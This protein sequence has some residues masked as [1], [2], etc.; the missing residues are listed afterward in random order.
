MYGY[1]YHYFEKYKEQ[2]V[3]HFLCLDF[4]LTGSIHA[5]KGN[6]ILLIY[7]TVQLLFA[8]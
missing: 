8:C 5:K 1:F 4:I 7:E 3:S 2:L 6:N